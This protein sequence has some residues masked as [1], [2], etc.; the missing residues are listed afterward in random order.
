MIFDQ[1]IQDLE[2]KFLYEHEQQDFMKKTM[3]RL[4]KDRS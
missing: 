3:M 2:K 4:Q 1:A